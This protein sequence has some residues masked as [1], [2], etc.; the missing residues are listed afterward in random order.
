MTQHQLRAPS[1]ALR[2]SFARRLPQEASERRRGVERGQTA[3]H[4][5]LAR[6]A[7]PLVVRDHA[8]ALGTV[9]RRFTRSR[10]SASPL[11]PSPRP[12]APACASLRRCAPKV[13]RGK[14]LMVW[15][16]S[17]AVAT[18]SAARP[19]SRSGRWRL[20]SRRRAL[21]ATHP[22][23]RA[24]GNCISQSPPAERVAA[25]YFFGV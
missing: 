4:Q 19:P 3:E 13:A 1:E 17:H 10:A 14:R 20:S 22:W 7:A 9:R 2:P 23:L 18:P 12:L 16:C 11:L 8:L 25:R 24:K 15:L 5:L 21:A 6:P